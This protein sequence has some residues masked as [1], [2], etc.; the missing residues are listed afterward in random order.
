MMEPRLLLLLA[1]DIMQK[2]LQALCQHSGPVC[3]DVGPRHW[4][5]LCLSLLQG[6]DLWA[7][8]VP[9]GIFQP[10]CLAGDAVAGVP[11]GSCV[12]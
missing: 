5:A 12:R 1:S 3:T 10:L 9:F 11:P 7:L 2:G 8:A 6:V 4:Q